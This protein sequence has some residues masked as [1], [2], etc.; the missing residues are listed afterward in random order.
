VDVGHGVGTACASSPVDAGP[1][2]CVRQSHHQHRD[3]EDLHLMR[4]D[5][6]SDHT[7]SLGV[8]RPDLTRETDNRRGERRVQAS[9]TVELPVPESVD[10]AGRPR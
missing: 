6:G 4:S 7:R 2:R 3:R 9:H 8:V 5:P 10:G 1:V